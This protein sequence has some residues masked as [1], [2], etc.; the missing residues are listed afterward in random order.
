MKI[1][2]FQVAFPDFSVIDDP[3]RY[4][5]SVKYE[6]NT[7]KTAG[8]YRKTPKKA[9][10]IYQIEHGGRKHTGVVALN[11]VEDF[12]AG[13]VKKHE[14]TLG[15]KE[16]LHMNLTLEWKAVLKPVLLTYPAV[17]AIS[18]WLQNYT[19]HH[20]TIFN[21][22]FGKRGHVHR[23]WQ[24]AQ[25]GDIE[26]LQ[27]LFSGRVPESYIADGHHRTTTMALLHER[28]A[29][30]PELDVDHLFCAFFAD[31]QLDILDY[32]RA[33]SALRNDRSP[34]HFLAELSKVFEIE[35][36]PE[37]RKPEKNH[38]LTLFLGKE[39]FR[40]QWRPEILAQYAGQDVLFDATLLNER[41]LRDILNI[42]DVRTDTRIE[43]VDGS[44]GLRG[45][46]KACS[47]LEVGF[48][49]FPVTFDNLIRVAD[50]GGSLP[51]K[52]TY[53]EPRLKSGVLVHLLDHA[54]PQQ[55]TAQ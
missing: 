45:I 39:W 33:V 18:E 44:K 54:R 53:F 51:P 13:K 46:E 42:Q 3:D 35:P 48:V 23:V 8:L 20:H 12:F 43:Y 5:T 30:Y 52:S 49:L 36:L 19:R 34:L 22:R 2:P 14:N 24:I 50:S 28:K 4:C 9:L 16:R 32:N 15:E 29:Q 17:P 11:D 10:Y 41:V 40:L 26:A 31:D 47:R 25:P 21:T 27:T 55:T 7:H 37:A 6:F 38:E 1:K